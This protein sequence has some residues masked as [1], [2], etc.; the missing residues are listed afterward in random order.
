MDEFR[1][2]SYGI[3]ELLRVDIWLKS[4]IWLFIKDAVYFKS[5]PVVYVN[6]VE[7]RYDLESKEIDLENRN[8][9][10]FDGTAVACVPLTM[11]FQYSG[12]G[13][14]NRQE[15][16]VQLNLDAKNSKNPRLHFLS[17][18]GKSSINQT[19]SLTKGNFSNFLDTLGNNERLLFPNK[20]I[21]PI[22]DRSIYACGSNF[23]FGSFDLCL[24]A[25]K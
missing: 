8:C 19:F 1:R 11:C 9:T 5:R 18:E 20:Y 15:I 4:F 7:I 17:P 21:G 12:R 2:N 22:F 25:D 6:P 3:R 24:E 16:E 23:S 13:V 14:E 10:L